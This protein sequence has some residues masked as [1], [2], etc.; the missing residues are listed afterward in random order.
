MGIIVIA[1]YF[2]TKLIMPSGDTSVITED[3]KL[4][5]QQMQFVIHNPVS[6]CKYI[7]IHYQ[8]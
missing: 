6:I 7:L 2:I 5:S 1:L 4:A 3:A 8:V